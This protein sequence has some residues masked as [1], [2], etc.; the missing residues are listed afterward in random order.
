MPVLTFLQSKIF[1]FSNK[2]N[3]KLKNLLTWIT[4][5]LQKLIQHK[6]TQNKVKS[7]LKCMLWNFSPILLT[8]VS[9]FWRKSWNMEWREYWKCSIISI[10]QALFQR[11]KCLS[12]FRWIFEKK[13][14]KCPR[15]NIWFLLKRSLHFS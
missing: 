2:H 8:Q 10:S 15:V 6:W 12:H 11:Q 5:K 4:N 14:E 7:I 13:T 9:Y 3:I 1:Q